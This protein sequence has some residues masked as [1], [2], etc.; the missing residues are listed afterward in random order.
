[1]N[2]L[3]FCPKCGKKSLCWE[4]GKRWNRPECTFVLYHN[5]A[6]AVAVVV[7]CGDEILLTRRNQEPAK[8]KLDLAGGFTDPNES[9]EFACFRELKE[10]LDIEIDTGK[11]RFLMSL[12]NIYHYK[13]IDYN[14][15]DL[16]FEYRVEEKF[17]V[18]LEKSEIAETVWVKKENIQ[19][20][21]IAFPSQR[22]FFERF[23]NKN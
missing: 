14:T 21:D 2:E 3:N 10:E 20:E 1:M 13:G 22:L 18:N 5:C 12:P 16:F 7:I 17:S 19:L 9:A 4:Q 11:L 23:L 6:A 15:L 8:G